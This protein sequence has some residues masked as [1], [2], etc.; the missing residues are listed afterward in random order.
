MISGYA[1]A[2]WGSDTTERRSTSGFCLYVFGN[3]VSWT[4]KKQSTVAMST[5]EAEFIALSLCASEICW[6][7]NLLVELR[8]FKENTKVIIYEDNQSAIRSCN[9]FEQLKR[10]KHLDIKYH[11]A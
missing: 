1:D 4:S 3:I 9:S 10:M 11:F 6:L 2:D 7:R 8:L 5:T